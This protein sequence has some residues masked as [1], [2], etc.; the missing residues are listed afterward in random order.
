M[1]YNKKIKVIFSKQDELTL[2]GQSKVCNWLYNQL[3]DLCKKDY[4]ECENSIKL[5]DGRNLRN[6]VLLYKNTHTFLNSV[7]SS[8]LKNTALR[9]KESFNRFFNKQSGYPKFRSF[10]DKWFSLYFDESNKGFKL[11]NSNKLRISLG[12]DIN[13]K[14]MYVYGDLKE[15]LKLSRNKKLK[16]FRL[17]KQQG[18]IF[19]A[20]FTI[21]STTPEVKPIETWISIDQNHKNFFVAIDNEGRTFEFLKL[22]QDKYF[23]SIIDKLKSKRDLC[24]KKHKKRTTT[25]SKTTYYVPNRRYIKL[26]DAL[27]KAYARRREQIK[28]IMYSIAH[29]IA[30][31]YDKVIIGDYVPSKNTAIY[32][33]MNRSMLN[34]EHIGEFRKILEWVM[35]KSK[36]SFIKVSERDTTKTCCICGHT[37]K[38]TPDIR[39]FTCCKCNTF[40]LRDVNSAINI[41]KKDGYVSNNPVLDK[42]NKVGV[43]NFK[44]QRLTVI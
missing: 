3:L 5:M 42:I 34:Q 27:N 13:N 21:E 4:F 6:V 20:I 29:F 39:E 32:N 40:I 25:M 30:K 24:N 11:I 37:E 44:Q 15:S 14:Q 2:D 9:L 17:C 16:T 1:K 7:H 38:K 12:K 23:D 18:G 26:N 31:N 28:Q 19:Y 8:P 43:F 22:F 33:N 10:K 41:A 35:T 36:K